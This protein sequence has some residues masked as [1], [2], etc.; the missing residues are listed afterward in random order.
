MEAGAVQAGNIYTH[1]FIIQ[2]LLHGSKAATRSLL[3]G[4]TGRLGGQPNREGGAG[5]VGFCGG[6][7]VLLS[8]CPS[9][10]DKDRKSQTSPHLLSL[11]L[12]GLSKANSLWSH[13]AN[14]TEAKLARRIKPVPDRGKHNGCPP[15][16]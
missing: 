16:T 14:S 13:S 9:A 6:G 12:A 4:M 2:N 15:R 7:G 8:R 11:R 5:G 10:A 3:N 1:L